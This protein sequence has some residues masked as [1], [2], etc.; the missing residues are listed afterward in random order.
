MAMSRKTVPENSIWPV[1]ISSMASSGVATTPTIEES[2]ALT[3]AAA[4]LPPAIEVNAIDACTVEG[5]KVK[6]RMPIY[7]PSPSTKR[8]GESAK[9]TSGN[10]TNVQLRIIRCRR[11]WIRPR[12]AS[13]VERRAPYR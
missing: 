4:T 3:I 1:F 7:S 2:E 8:S 9:P 10:S 5:T 13:A 12:I 6:N 11:Q